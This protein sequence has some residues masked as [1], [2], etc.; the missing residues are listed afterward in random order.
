MISELRPF[1]KKFPRIKKFH[2]YKYGSWESPLLRKEFYYAGN[3]PSQFR[4][5][6]GLN[7]GLTEGIHIDP[8]EY[9]TI[10]DRDKFFKIL[11]R[12]LKRDKFYFQKLTR[13]AI[14]ICQ[15]NERAAEKFKTIK[16]WQK[17]NR[18]E[19]KK[20]YEFFKKH[21]F[22][23]LPYSYLGYKMM[24]GPQLIKYALKLSGISEKEYLKIGTKL[25]IPP[26]GRKTPSGK[27]VGEM[28]KIALYIKEAIPGWRKIFS[29]SE[30]KIVQRLQK[31]P[32]LLKLLSNYLK[33][34]EWI[35]VRHWTGK[36]MDLRDVIKNLREF[37]G[38]SDLRESIE[39]AKEREKKREKEFREIIKKYK[40]TADSLAI[41]NLVRVHAWLRTHRK[42]IMSKVDLYARPLLQ[43]IARRIGL[44]FDQFIYLR[45]KEVEDFIYRNKKPNPSEIP[46]RQQGYGLFVLGGKFYVLVGQELK[47]FLS[48]KII[49]PI[50]LKVIKGQTANPGK[51]RGPVRVVLFD[52]DLEKIRKGEILVSDMTNPNYLPYLGKV[53]AFVTDKGGMLSHA[54]ILSRE[55]NKPCIIGTQIATKVLKNGDI[56]EVDAT[57][58]IIKLLGT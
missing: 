37:L 34:F 30:K 33:N 41:I 8:I 1:V 44:T 27:A 4:K 54:A 48:K 12:A 42:E 46:L 55:L 52:A 36:P 56:V 20:W 18:K 38:K 43:E 19:L 32:K 49:R 40:F 39:A 15:E 13:K 11:F 31:Y 2:W 50:K 26:R 24:L 47:K 58:G 29:G 53:K 25:M 7:I 6:S 21:Y 17:L 16:D 35:T 45:L 51:V 28:I 22:S 57:K 5:F 9:A 3:L 14:K 23:I 10:E